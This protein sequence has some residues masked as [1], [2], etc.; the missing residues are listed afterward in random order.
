MEKKNEERRQA[1]KEKRGERKEV[2]RKGIR[3]EVEEERCEEGEQ[4]KTG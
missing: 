3:A 4:T 2:R 1:W